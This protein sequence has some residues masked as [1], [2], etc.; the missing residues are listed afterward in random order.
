LKTTQQHEKNNEATREKQR[1][2][3]RKNS[4]AI[5]QEK[6]QNN[7]HKNLCQHE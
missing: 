6:Q 1:G 3:A 5:V 2:S 4:N 7:T